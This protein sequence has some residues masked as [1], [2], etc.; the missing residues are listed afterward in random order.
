VYREEQRQGHRSDPNREPRCHSRACAV[1]LCRQR[2]RKVSSCG[3][4]VR[5]EAG[6]GGIG[7]NSPREHCSSCG[8][9]TLWLQGVLECSGVAQ[10]VV[11][12]REG[13]ALWPCV[14]RGAVVWCS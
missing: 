5:E 9:G 10:H 14:S 1:G 8:A 13:L 12:S 7:G 3:I 2:A 11:D 6:K 4:T